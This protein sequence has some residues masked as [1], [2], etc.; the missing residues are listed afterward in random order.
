VFCPLDPSPLPLSYRIE[1]D[2]ALYTGVY[3]T[4]IRRS[5]HDVDVCF[6]GQIAVTSILVA[7][8]VTP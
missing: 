7:E 2:Q 4:R 3:P 1:D 8:H 5:R 6:S